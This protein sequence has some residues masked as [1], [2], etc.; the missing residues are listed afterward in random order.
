[1]SWALGYDEHWQ[2]DIGYGVPATCDQLGCGAAID[3]GLA[4]VCGGEPY[5]GRSGCGLYFCSKHLFYGGARPMRQ[6]CDQCIERPAGRPYTPSPDTEEWNR[7]KAT[8]ES[9]HR[10]RV[11]HGCCEDEGCPQYGTLHRCVP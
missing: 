7:H 4:Y 1:M 5:G 10:W 8:D 11:E 2:R 6:L 9:W 3:R